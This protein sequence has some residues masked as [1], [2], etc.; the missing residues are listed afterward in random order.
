LQETN[1]RIPSELSLPELQER[2]EILAHALDG[3]LDS[4]LPPPE[5]IPEEAV[6]RRRNRNDLE[7]DG[8][9]E[10]EA[11]SA[12][13]RKHSSSATKRKNA[14]SSDDD[15]DDEDMLRRLFHSSTP[16]ANKKTVLHHSPYTCSLKL[17]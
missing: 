17:V 3:R 9:S 10:P 8:D 15:D 6:S 5:A 7:S 12:L 13:A 14:V 16:Q 11:S 2:A 4:L 1:W